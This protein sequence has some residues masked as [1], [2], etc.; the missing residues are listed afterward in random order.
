MTEIQCDTLAIICTVVDT[1]NNHKNHKYHQQTADNANT[2]T[3]WSCSTQLSSTAT[4]QAIS[5]HI[6]Q[7]QRK[8]QP[9]PQPEAVPTP[10]PANFRNQKVT[11]GPGR[12]N[13]VPNYT[14]NNNNNYMEQLV[15]LAL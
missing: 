14:G 11:F 15:T 12:I 9:Q 8:Q 7:V 2:R 5:M 10:R 6:H 4:E 13:N 1:F 3:K